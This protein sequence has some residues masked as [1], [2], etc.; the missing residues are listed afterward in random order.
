M[1]MRKMKKLALLLVMTLVM[2]LLTGCAQNVGI[3]MND[4][5]TGSMKYSMMV[6]Q[7]VYKYLGSQFGS[8][9]EKSMKTMGYK[10]TETIID[11]E[12][13]VEFSKSVKYNSL[14]ELKS[15]LT[16]SK[17]FSEKFIGNVD[18]RYK[19]TSNYRY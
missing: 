15:I 1:Q 11:N 13:M 2:T 8:E 7:S 19:S 12:K 9:F 4:D 10:K 3:T 16:N 5:G 6:E 14:K 18:C 17:T